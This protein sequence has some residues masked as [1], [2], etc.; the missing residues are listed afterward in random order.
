MKE[1]PTSTNKPDEQHYLALAIQPIDFIVANKLD[2]LE[3]NIIKYV[4]RYKFKDGMK[5]LIK[6]KNYL[7]WL[8]KKEE[9]AE[10]ISN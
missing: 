6:A 4:S 9:N 5:D 8:I 10:K 3:G 2:Y 7:D 1:L